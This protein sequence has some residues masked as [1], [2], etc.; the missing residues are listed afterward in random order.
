MKKIL[1]FVLAAVMLFSISGLSV[2]A[3]D[4]GGELGNSPHWE[5][6][7][8]SA[9][10]KIT[11]TGAMPDYTN[12]NDRPWD[13]YINNNKI[14]KVTIGDGVTSIGPSAFYNCYSLTSIDI[15]NS[16]TSIGDN[17]FWSCG[18]LKNITI[19]DSVTSIGISAFSYCGKLSSLPIMNG[20]KSIEAG[21]FSFCEGF[22]SITVPNNVEHIGNGAFQECHN[23]TSITFE[24]DTPPT[25]GG[26]VVFENS[27][28][29]TVFI[30]YGANE[31]VWRT[32]LEG[33]GLKNFEIKY[34][35]Q[36]TP[37]PTPDPKPTPTPNT[38]EKMEQNEKPDPT[39]RKAM[40][41]YDF[42]MKVKTS[43]KTAKAGKTLRF[44]VSKEITNMPASVMETLRLCD[45]EITLVLKWNGRTITIPAE[46]AVKKPANKIFWTVKQLTERYA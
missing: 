12:V 25:F 5:F 14:E 9:T 1:T 39:D 35:S 27:P 28:I 29:K 34:L 26:N 31:T 30:P 11:G 40:E 21:A 42:W 2:W 7:A 38:I 43:I 41:T 19:P 36:P 22:S 8:A 16:V 33:A 32:A 18:T 37:T 10:L 24:R 13:E 3:A 20:V 6:D 4:A 44:N 17:A 45:K 15:P 46:E 23:L